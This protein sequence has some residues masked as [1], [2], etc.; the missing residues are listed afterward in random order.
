MERPANLDP[1]FD[2][3]IKDAG[4]HKLSMEEKI[5]YMEA[6]H[7]NERER[8]VIHEG[9]Y[10]I[11]KQDGLEEGIAKVAKNLL[12]MGLSAET[13]SEATGLSAEEIAAL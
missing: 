4:T 11:G 10:I 13:V 3:V 2:D 6:L 12:S 5:K 8:Q 1:S 7:L 9:G